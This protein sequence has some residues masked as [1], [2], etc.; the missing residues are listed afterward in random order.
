M[1]DPPRLD[2]SHQPET[3]SQGSGSEVDAGLAPDASWAARIGVGRDGMSIEQLEGTTYG[4]FPFRTDPEKIGE[5]ASLVGG[6]EVPRSIAGALLFVVTPHLLADER[7]GDA[8]RSVIHG[9]QAFTWHQLVPFG[10]ELEVS[11]TVSRVRQR[12]EVAFTNFDLEVTLAGSPA[13]TGASTFLMSAGSTTGGAHERPEPPPGSGHVDRV[14]GTIT[15]ESSVVGGF[16]ASRADLVRYAGASRDWNPIHWDHASAATAGLPGIVVHG[17]FQSGWVTEAAVRLGLEPPAARFRYR[18][19]LPAGH[20]VRLTARRK[21]E[22]TVMELED[23]DGPYLT[24]T[25]D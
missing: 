16:G 10:V 15:D 18:R 20:E 8:T 5:Y 25:F 13:I 9:D 23:D 19:P 21:G 2:Y 17:L 3:R 6:T 24:A 12:G 14:A 22:T 1:A 7:A 11:G 4:P